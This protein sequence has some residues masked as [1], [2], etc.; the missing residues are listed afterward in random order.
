MS[1]VKNIDTISGNIL[2]PT[3]SQIYAK[4]IIVDD[5]G[6]ENVV[7]NSYTGIANENYVIDAS[8]TKTATNNL[9]SFTIKLANGDGYFLDKFNGGELVKIYT[10]VTGS[11]SN[12]TFVGKIDNV[13]YGLNTSDGFFVDID[14]RDYP[15]LI[16]KTI[17]IRFV[18]KSTDVS[19]AN[20]LYNNYPEFE[21]RFNDGTQWCTATY[22]LVN[23]T[24]VWSPSASTF[25]ATLVNISTQ[26]T[27]GWSIITDICTRAGLDCYIDYDEV[28]NKWILATFVSGSIV[29]ESGVSYG[30]NLMSLSD[31]GINTTDISNRIIVYGKEENASILLSTKEDT[32]SQTNLWVKD[33]V[34]KDNSLITMDEVSDK[35]SS[36]LI[37]G[38]NLE[39]RGR[40]TSLLIENLKPGIKIP[41]VVPYCNINDYYKVYAFTHHLTHPFTTDVEISKRAIKLV[42]LFVNQLDF[43]SIVDI[44]NRYSMKDA[45]TIFFDENDIITGTFNDTEQVDS[46][47]QLSGSNVTGTFTSGILETDYNISTIELRISPVSMPDCATDVYEVSNDGGI[48]FKTISAGTVVNFDNYGSNPTELLYNKL[49]I[50]VTLNKITVSPVYESICC[51]Y[52]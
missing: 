7:M 34:I 35:A 22:D 18:L 51:L 4:I 8:C 47:L 3:E 37:S 17:T 10:N 40:L 24:V 31:Y 2:I 15:E 29:G 12:P 23:E 27:K 42:D 39:Y 5:T 32:A 19:L 45:Y 33:K 21:L 11:F 38:I 49:V 52:K 30:V 46:Y 14:G 1:S 43:N 36:E 28:N 41:I 20:I 9:G 25:P 48:T 26:N 16:D 6:T 44:I 50:R 13:N